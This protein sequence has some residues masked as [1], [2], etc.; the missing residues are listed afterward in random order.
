MVNDDYGDTP[1]EMEVTFT[2]ILLKFK[3]HNRPWCVQ[4]LNM[5]NASILPL[6]E[7]LDPRKHDPPAT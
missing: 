3:L 4:M 7:V 6:C 2:E 1:E 5:L